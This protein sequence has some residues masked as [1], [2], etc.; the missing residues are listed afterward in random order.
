M[1]VVLPWLAGSRV[2]CAETVELSGQPATRRF[3]DEN[4]LVLGGSVDLGRLTYDNA[5]T[6]RTSFNFAPRAAW[7]VVERMS[8]G[9]SLLFDYYRSDSGNPVFPLK[10]STVRY[11][12]GAT[13]GYDIPVSR[14]ASMWFTFGAYFTR[15]EADVEAPSGTRLVHGQVIPLSD[16]EENIVSVDFFAPILLHPVPH[17]FLGAGPQV[18][19][20]VVHTTEDTDTKRLYVGL[21]TIIGG[22]L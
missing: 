20:D 15:L 8:L 1:L 16:Y 4:T 6:S 18:F 9:A 21:S 13:L 19:A 3:G 5:A 17:L 11:G 12:G 10:E 22:W 14:L 7:F 2:A